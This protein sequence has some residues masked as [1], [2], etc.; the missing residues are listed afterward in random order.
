M[1]YHR[2]FEPK[3]YY[4]AKKIANGY[5]G[6]LAFSYATYSA[7]CSIDV[8]IGVF[9]ETIHKY[10]KKIWA[11]SDSKA[12]F[13]LILPNIGWLDEKKPHR[14]V[15]D[16]NDMSDISKVCNNIF[17]KV[18]TLSPW[19][20]STYSNIDILIRTYENYRSQPWPLCHDDAY[21]VLPLL[22]LV[23]NQ[24]DIGLEYLL[25][26]LCRQEII[27]QYDMPYIEKYDSQFG[28][29][30]LK[31]IHIG[32]L[33]SVITESGDKRFF[34]FVSKDASQFN[35]DVIRIFK[36]AYSREENPVTNDIINDE[37]DSYMHT[38]VSWGLY[39]GMWTR[40]DTDC[41]IGRMD[42][43]FRRSKD[44]GRF[45]LFEKR[46]STNWE[47]WTI[48]QP[49]QDVGILPKEYYSADIG[50]IGSPSMVLKRISEGYFPSPWYPLF[51]NDY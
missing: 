40:Y 47:V 8:S 43:S 22:Y 34:Q 41:N 5:W 19:F 2:G 1:C 3:G 14:A 28:E 26:Y 25:K 27:T 29:P 32:D 31:D 20:F 18:D 48:N 9:N 4:Y 16:I 38:M 46:V 35:S 6:L 51:A 30:I 17:D 24:K 13:W 44:Y 45:P 37:L 36:R 15:W 33:F 12:L 39:L 7:C 10:S 49:K 11:G 21:R 23:N 50:D 42:I